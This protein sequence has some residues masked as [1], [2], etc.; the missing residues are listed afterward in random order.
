MDYREYYL[1]K[2][3]KKIEDGDQPLLVSMPKL[4][5]RR[6]GNDGPVFL[7]PELCFMT[8]LTDE[9]RANFRLMKAMAEYTRQTPDKRV[10]TL[11]N[12]SQRIN[13]NPEIK[14]VLDDWNLKFC[15]DLQ[16]FQARILKP[17]TIHG[18][19]GF[20]FNYAE[21]N[22]DWGKAF[23]R[24]QVVSTVSV[25]N[26]SIVYSKKDEAATLNFVKLLLQAGPPAG[27]P[28]AQPRMFAIA[29]NRPNT[30]MMQLNKVVDEKP[31]IVMVVVPNNKGEHYHAVKKLCCVEK[32]T[33]SQVM[34]YS[35][36]SREKGL[37][38]VASKVAMQM[39]CKLGAE[40]WNIEFPLKDTMIMGYNANSDSSKK[41]TDV[42]ALV[43]SLNPAFSKY[44]ST[45]IFRK[46]DE[47]VIKEIGPAVMKALRRYR[48]EN[49]KLPI[50]IIMYRDGLGE[51]QIE[52]A[53][54]RE[55][56]AIKKVFRDNGLEEMKFTYIIVSKRINTRFFMGGG[57]PDNP[58]SGT[59]VDDVV[60]LP[61]RY[62]FFLISQSVRQGTVNPTSYNVI[63]DKSG[64][65]PD[66][67]QKLTYKLTHLYYNW[68]GT[69][70][71]SCILLKFCV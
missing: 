7:V 42:G 34:T 45:C 14:Q 60:T 55:I 21:N 39:G 5:E 51:G 38:S 59:V 47:D 12:F 28:L 17:E 10:E 16:K 65:K 4:K 23:N 53:K 9:Q 29:D 69:V 67:I 37:G 63:E 71:V 27:I 36:I 48:E 31:A 56:V 3:D 40:P 13:N 62:D 24:W 6:G 41:G 35:V 30:Y 32:P 43:S 11:N 22:A 33:P 58:P 64:L 8:G 15:Q 26:W 49:G 18:A 2:H 66:Q 61:E 52:Y 70:R 46:S 19:K 68:S 57:R 44:S 25:P 1:Q 20:K 54:D 50:R